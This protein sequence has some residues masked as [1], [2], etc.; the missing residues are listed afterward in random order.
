MTKHLLIEDIQTDS[1]NQILNGEDV[2]PYLNFK[3]SEVS[4]MAMTTKSKKGS[5]FFN[6]NKDKK[7]KHQSF[8]NLD[9]QLMSQLL[10]KE[11]KFTT[12]FL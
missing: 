8:Q 2:S 1:D 12:S 10:N 9:A 3:K 5:V 11:G 7:L 6:R 4:G